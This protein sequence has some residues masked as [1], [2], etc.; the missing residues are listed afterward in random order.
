MTLM[1]D[2]RSAV[3]NGPGVH[4]L[5]AGVSAY[6]HLPGGGGPPASMTFGLGQLGSAALTVY[7]VYNWLLAHQAEFPVPLATVRMLLSPSP[8]EIAVEPALAGLAD[9]CNFN[10]LSQEAQAWREDAK[11]SRENVTVFYWAGHGIQLTLGDSVL[12]LDNFGDGIGGPVGLH[13]K[14]KSIYDGMA[15]SLT[16]PDIARTQIYLVDACRAVPDELKNQLAQNT[17]DLW[18]SDLPGVDDRCAPIFYGALPGALAYARIGV[19]TLFSEALLKCLDGAA[20]E[21][22]EDENGS[23][24]WQVTVT[25][26]IS[27]LK[28][29]INE[30]NATVPPEIQQDFQPSGSPQPKAILTLKQPPAVPLTLRIDPPDALASAKLVIQNSEGEVLEELPVPVTPHPYARQLPAGVYIVKGRVDPPDPLLKPN[31]TSAQQV[32]PPR[33]TWKVS[34]AK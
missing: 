31:Y 3:G 5:L 14:T 6:P 18:F 32:K 9:R 23:A 15:P 21:I 33:H 7:K 1:I 12:L 22:V 10:N 30:I 17:A 25:Q 29:Q 16:F 34:L 20:A 4:A 26:L 19:Q 27:A 28:A 2:N 11:T 24:R 8:D 13:A